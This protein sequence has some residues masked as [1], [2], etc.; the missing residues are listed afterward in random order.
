VLKIKGKVC[1]VTQSH[2]QIE[3]GPIAQFFPATVRVD[4]ERYP[5]ID[6][7]RDAANFAGLTFLK[8]EVLFQGDAIQLDRKYLELVRKKGY[9]M[10]HL[11]REAEYQA[12]LHL[13][14]SALQNGSVQARSTGI[15]LVWFI[16]E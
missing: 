16:K 11:I 10:L 12:G 13:L 4:K 3:A 5:D 14:E 15:S 9:S 7:I 1:I 6:E 8:Q 2:R